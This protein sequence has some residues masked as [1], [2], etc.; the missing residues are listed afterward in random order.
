VIEVQ[1][2]LCPVDR[3]EISKTA[4]QTAVA[5]ARWYRAGLRVLEVVA[6][7][8]QP[9]P[10]A[11][12]QVVGLTVEVRGEIARELSRFLADANPEGIAAD[13]AV[14]EGE[15]AQGIL[16]AARDL[17]A[18]LIVIG[19][20]GRGGFERFT[21]G[22][23]A[24][25]VLRKAPCPVLIVPPHARSTV[26]DRSAPYRRMLC[27]VDFSEASRKGVQY[28]LS[29]AQESDAT[30]TLM[31]VIDWPA[32]PDL[33]DTLR[34]FFGE[35]RERWVEERRRDLQA[36][37]PESA[38]TWCHPDAHVVVGAPGR[39]ILRTAEERS[40]ELIVMGVHGRGALD[41]A[42][43]GST[44]HQVVRSAPCPVLT[45]RERA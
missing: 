36:L 31:H 32:Y 5:L 30:L 1:N 14:E 33:P 3:S 2:I 38:R 34:D 21:V 35:H 18:D 24:E 12:P 23:I 17:P 40:A 20:H 13:V 26:R 11:R 41:L 16:D 8:L 6:V 7:P 45:V 25:K 37:I 44:A 27:A 43:F 15:I 22:S 10:M 28:A 39:E 9:L 19:T 29:L 42:I 4:L